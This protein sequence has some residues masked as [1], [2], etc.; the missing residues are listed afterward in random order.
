MDRTA[1]IALAL[2][3]LVLAATPARAQHQPCM[4]DGRNYPEDATV[5]SGGLLLFCS[6]G[7]WQNNQGARCDD[8][9]GAY[10]GPRRPFTE[11]N[12][13]PIPDFYKEKY[14]ELNLH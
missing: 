2:I 11:Y 7:T 8:P 5:C 4:L 3:V 12:R 1:K 13:E 9:S 14:P 6:N 10:V